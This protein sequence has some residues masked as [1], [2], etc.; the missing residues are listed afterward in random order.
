VLLVEDDPG[1][2]LI[3]H[4][5]FAEHGLRTELT[6]VS[7]VDQALAWLRDPDAPRT[8]LILLDLGLPGGEGMRLLG[9][10]KADAAFAHIPVVI[11]TGSQSEADILR[12]YDLH[13]S[14]YII[15]PPDLAAFTEV[16]QRIDGFYSRTA[17]V[18][19]AATPG[20]A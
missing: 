11:L 3:I 10:V 15:K 16:V 18:S 13:A 9:T 6:A 1:D 17:Q 12:G 19:H 2:Q 4:E 14:A 5:A 7:D 20:G 8:D